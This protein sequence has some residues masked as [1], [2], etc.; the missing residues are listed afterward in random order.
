MVYCP[1]CGNE[2][3]ERNRFCPNCGHNLVGTS[4][5]KA[6]DRYNGGY[7]VLGFFF[8]IVGL[9]LYLIWNDEYPLRA[10][11]CGKGALIGVI[12][13]AAVSL[14]VWIIFVLQFGI[15]IRGM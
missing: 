12:V 4:A 7:A 13:Q 1:N 3:S 2:L 9:I 14:V 6:P 11:S 10:K 8:P 15:L 5:G